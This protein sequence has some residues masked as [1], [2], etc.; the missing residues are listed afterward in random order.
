[1][2]TST[3]P[4]VRIRSDE[5]AHLRDGAPWTDKGEVA[6]RATAVLLA[7]Q[8][9]TDERGAPIRRRDEH[10]HAGSG[11]KDPTE[12]RPHL[13]DPEFPRPKAHDLTSH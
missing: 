9:S 10:A 1:M 12:R 3:T 8:D 11:A 2:K 6:P 5:E 7:E 13:P 4:E